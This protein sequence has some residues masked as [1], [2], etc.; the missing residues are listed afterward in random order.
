MNAKYEIYFIEWSKFSKK[1]C[2]EVNI[3]N[4]SNLV[5][6]KEKQKNGKRHNYILESIAQKLTLK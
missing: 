1:Q 3:V 4:T 2:R 6:K 5:T